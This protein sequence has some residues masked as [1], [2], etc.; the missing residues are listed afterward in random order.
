MMLLPSFIT[1]MAACYWRANDRS[2]AIEAAQKAID[3]LKSGKGL[4]K[5][6]LVAYESQLQEYKGK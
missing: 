5:K 1:K 2:K 6:S 3:L 4:A